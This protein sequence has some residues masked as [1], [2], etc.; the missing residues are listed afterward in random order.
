MVRSK[1]G[2]WSHWVNATTT[3]NDGYDKTYFKCIYCDLR[4]QTNVTRFKQHTVLCQ[5]A[6]DDVK[7]KFRTT[8][9]SQSIATSKQKAELGLQFRTRI[10]FYHRHR[11]K[12]FHQNLAAQPHCFLMMNQKCAL[13]VTQ[14][15]Q[16]RL[17][18]T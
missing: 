11:W 16:R 9:L 1:D 8:V 7:Q 3:T 15:V 14:N 12:A 10:L 6:P 18:Q 2:I 13:T 5:Q 17:I 4:L